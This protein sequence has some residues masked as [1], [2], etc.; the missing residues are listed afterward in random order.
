[1]SGLAALFSGLNFQSTIRRYCDQIGWRIADINDRRAL[2]KFNMR[3]G[4]TQSLWIVRYD[5]TLEF[6]V[7]SMAQFDS[8]DRIPHY[9]STVLLKRSAQNKIGFWCIEQISGRHVFSYMHNAEMSL[10]NVQYFERVVNA[11][12]TECDTFE[13]ILIDMLR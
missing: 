3:S 11:L 13:G 12:V 9:L 10:I 4:R 7:P 1:M 6:S 5:T 8:E 2:L